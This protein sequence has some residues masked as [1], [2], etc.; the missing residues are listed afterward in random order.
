MPCHYPLWSSALTP[1]F[2]P[3]DGEAHLIGMEK[4]VF[5]CVSAAHPHCPMCL[6]LTKKGLMKAGR[7]RGGR[8]QPALPVEMG[9][10][11]LRDGIGIKFPT[12]RED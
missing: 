12:W 6:C 8:V 10:T 11:G 7:D 1:C 3:G 4:C 9:W 2:S 5:A